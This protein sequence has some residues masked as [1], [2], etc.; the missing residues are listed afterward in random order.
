MTP[1]SFEPDENC[2]HRKARFEKIRRLKKFLRPLPRRSNVHRYPFLKYFSDW[3]RNKTYL[4]SIRP[5]QMIP[6]LYIGSIIT[7]LPLQGI[8]IPLSFLA[9]IV[10][11]ANLPIIIALQFL[12]NAFTLPFIYAIDYYLGD[13][14]LSLF[15]K[16]KAADLN[17]DKASNEF[18]EILQST[19]IKDV[20][21]WLMDIINNCFAI[22]IDRGPYFFMAAMLGGLLLGIILGII[23]HIG[24]RWFWNHKRF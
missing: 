3:S 16:A 11:H 9:A 18:N 14:L 6:A 20:G 15:F 21:N 13:Q 2:P 8:Q 23:F 5:D 12:S 19:N 17:I 1:N 24:Y 7:I 4:W 10:F 22:L